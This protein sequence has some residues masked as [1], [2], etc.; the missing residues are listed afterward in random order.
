MKNKTSTKNAKVYALV[1]FG[2]IPDSGQGSHIIEVCGVS[3]VRY[4]LE[5][6]KT[7]K[8]QEL[9]DYFGDEEDE[10]DLVCYMNTDYVGRPEY[11]IIEVD[12]IP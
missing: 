11:E 9:N 4:L 2:E 5:N 12:F 6:L 8:E 1:L 10:E 7:K 3:P